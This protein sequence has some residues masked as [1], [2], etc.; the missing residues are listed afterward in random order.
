M[1]VD[2]ASRG[3]QEVST[4]IQ[5]VQQAASET[6]MA[7][8]QISDSS[9]DL[10]RQ[11]EV[12]REE[13]NAFLSEVRNDSSEKKL[14]VWDESMC[15]GDYEIDQEHIGFVNLLNDYYS[16]MMAGEGATIVD[17][18]MVRFAGMSRLHMEHEE[19]MMDAYNFP[20]ADQHKASHREFLDKFLEIQAGQNAGEDMSVEFLEYLSGWLKDHFLYADRELVEFVKQA[21]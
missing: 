6:G 9:A 13:V 19:D 11:A 7:A 3:T 2:Q 16:K 21:S 4:N 5:S 14:L 10:S 15:T 17:E 12:L 8:S 1:N 20:K 18:T